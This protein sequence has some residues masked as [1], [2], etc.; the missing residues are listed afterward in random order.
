MN[1]QTIDLSTD[2][3]GIATLTLNRPD[4]HNAMSSQM[5]ADIRQA[6]AT[7][8]SDPAIRGVVLTGTGKSFCAGADLGWMKDNFH[9]SRPE[10]IAE[11]EV[12]GLMLE[13]LNQL[14]RPLIAKVNGA[15]YAGGIGL[16]SVCDIAIGSLDATF[17]VTE[18][19]L[20]LMPAN[21]SSYLINRIGQ[22]NARRTFLNSH[23]FKGAEAVHLGLLDKAVDST[24]LDAVVEN[25]IGELLDCA[26][27][28]VAATKS[29]IRRITG[30]LD[31][32]LKQDTAEMLADCWEGEEAQ[33][34]I[35]AFFDRQPA[36]WKVSD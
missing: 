17:S 13:E 32:S 21:I 26:P 24:E 30:N 19:R 9:R 15:A 18:V 10:R 36:P 6:C 3:R 22:R 11:S 23:F 12:L 7:V 20:G 34:G 1:F 8:E 35:A 33:A 16:I 4:K 25:E 27:G 29:L 5:M 2:P 28:A 14:S 31:A